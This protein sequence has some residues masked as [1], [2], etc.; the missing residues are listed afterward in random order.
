MFPTLLIHSLR[1][2]QPR[3]APGLLFP[4]YGDG[5]GLCSLREETFIEEKEKSR[6]NSL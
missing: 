1:S 2:W 3:V 6:S 5:I 4:D